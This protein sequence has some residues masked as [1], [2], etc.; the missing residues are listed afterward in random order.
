MLVVYVKCFSNFP[1]SDECLCERNWDRTGSLRAKKDDAVVLL[2]TQ[3][4][5]VG[6]IHIT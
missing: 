3:M 5:E 4:W 6:F 1:C 2:F